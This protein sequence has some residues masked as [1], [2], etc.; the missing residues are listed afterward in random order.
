M[1]GPTTHIELYEMHA[2]DAP[3]A[4]GAFTRSEPTW[5]DIVESPRLVQPWLI[6]LT[7]VP[8]VGLLAVVVYGLAVDGATVIAVGCV[9]AG[10]AFM[11]GA[12]LGFLFG[13]PRALSGTAREPGLRSNT[14]LEQISD[15]L[16]KILV[17]V[18]L[19][20]IGQIADS[21]ARLVTSLGPALG[22]AP[23][24]EAFAAGLLTFFWATGFMIGYVITRAVVGPLFSQTEWVIG[25]RVKDS[26]AKHES[27][28]AG[29]TPT[30]Q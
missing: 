5:S 14:N 4:A 13:I 3:D 16:T 25:H 2:V 15:W 23:S 19:V 27:N 9:V 22:D 12:L 28:A 7:G 10:G 29:S 17:G 8:A 11:I 1:P 26:R 20:E 18:G 24:S 30:D 6:R 21:V